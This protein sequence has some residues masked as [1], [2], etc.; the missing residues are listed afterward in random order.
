M[1]K[2][3]KKSIIVISAILASAILASTIRVPASAQYYE[4]YCVN[5]AW[6]NAVYRCSSGGCDTKQTYASII[7]QLYPSVYSDPYRVLFSRGACE[8]KQNNGSF[9]KMKKEM[10]KEDLKRRRE[11]HQF[12]LKELGSFK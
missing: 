2:T 6:R 4:T 11:A 9:E 3:M 12:L 1:D 7:M 8:G 5:D 10:Q